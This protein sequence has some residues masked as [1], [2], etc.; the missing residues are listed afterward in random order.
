M[1]WRQ[2]VGEYGPAGIH[3][4]AAPPF[5]PDIELAGRHILG[6]A[7][8]QDEI[9]ALRGNGLRQI[10]QAGIG[11]RFKRNRRSPPHARRRIPDRN[12]TDSRRQCA[13][14]ETATATEIEHASA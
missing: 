7:V 4:E 13:G 11:V 5:K 14:D 6:D 8:D 2:Q 9:E 3:Q 1:R 10:D 12:A